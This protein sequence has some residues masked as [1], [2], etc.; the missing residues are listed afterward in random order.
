MILLEHYIFK[1]IIIIKFKI[2]PSYTVWNKCTI[3]SHRNIKKGFKLDEQFLPT[4]KVDETQFYH[5]FLFD[6]ESSETM[7]YGTLQLYD[8]FSFFAHIFSRDNVQLRNI[9]GI[10]YK[11]Q[12]DPFRIRRA[13]FSELVQARG[14]Y[15]MCNIVE[16]L[17]KICLYKYGLPV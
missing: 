9:T 1:N 4:I 8:W 12:F 17:L 16:S 6:R 15:N 5:K 2:E 3:E 7:T 14:S 13:D 10:L 11:I